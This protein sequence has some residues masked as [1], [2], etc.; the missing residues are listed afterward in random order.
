MAYRINGIGTI[1]YGHRDELPDSSYIPTRWFVLLYLPIFPLGS[2][3]VWEEKT[4]HDPFVFA[5]TIS[6]SE[7]LMVR[8]VDLNWTQVLLT[9]LVFYGSIF[10]ISSLVILSERIFH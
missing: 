8:A 4:K 2:F 10:L 9:Y 6:S 7:S 5:G 3:R 1:Y